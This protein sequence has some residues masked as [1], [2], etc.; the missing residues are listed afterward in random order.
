MEKYCASKFCKHGLD[1]LFV[2]ISSE[3]ISLSLWKAPWVSN[4]E[5]QPQP[6]FHVK[7]EITD[8]KYTGGLD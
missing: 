3:T 2:P 5:S 4:Q 8:K 1:I 6:A 7:G